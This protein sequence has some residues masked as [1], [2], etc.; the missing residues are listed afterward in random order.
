MPS[1]KHLVLYWAPAVA[2][3]AAIF[4]VSSLQPATIENTS[5]L[6]V[7]SAVAH[8]VEYTV[9]SLPLSRLVLAGGR[10][11]GISMWGIVLAATIAYGLSDE[12]HQAF[13]PGRVSSWV[14]VLYN[15]VGA[16]VG[17]TVAE[18]ATRLLRTMGLNGL[19]AVVTG[20]PQPDRTTAPLRGT[21][22]PVILSE[23]C[24]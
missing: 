10:Y 16:V 7:S 14:D 19:A 15:S 18:L 6:S 17:L 22:L 8:T 21:D 13:V 1:S 4:A 24:E 9:L 3:M 12:L 5:P 11:S 20:S 23:R 2:W